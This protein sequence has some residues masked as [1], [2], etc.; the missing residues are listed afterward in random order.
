VTIS[1]RRSSGLHGE[2]DDGKIIYPIA[3]KAQRQ[4]YDCK[5]PT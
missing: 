5:Q 1:P 3:S 4:M 2:D